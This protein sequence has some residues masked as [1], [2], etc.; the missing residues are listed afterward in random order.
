MG[1]RDAM[2][3]GD[4]STHSRRGMGGAS[5]GIMGHGAHR[6]R[7]DAMQSGTFYVCIFFGSFVSF[8][9]VWISSM[10]W[11]K[12]GGVCVRQSATNIITLQHTA[13][14]SA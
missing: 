12:V 4:M 11:Q 10:G 14:L 1:P 2:S 13:V 7:S 5:M 8:R 9:G 6:H 3:H